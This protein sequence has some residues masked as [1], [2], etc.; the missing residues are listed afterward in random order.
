MLNC[1]RAPSSSFVTELTIF[2]ALS[3]DGIT[4]RLATVG[5]PDTQERLHHGVPR[6]GG[7]RTARKKRLDMSD[8]SGDYR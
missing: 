4:L 3:H 5:K 1:T 7:S 2:T 6:H 8:L